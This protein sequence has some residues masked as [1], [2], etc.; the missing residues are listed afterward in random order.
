MQKS[1]GQAQQRRAFLYVTLWLEVS[2]GSQL[3]EV[4]FFCASQIIL[5]RSPDHFVGWGRLEGA[6][7]KKLG[8]KLQMLQRISP[9]RQL[10]KSKSRGR[11]DRRKKRCG[12]NVH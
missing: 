10:L 4:F 2:P 12:L 9:C 5:L 1:E 8:A 3:V 11:R 6:S 7:W